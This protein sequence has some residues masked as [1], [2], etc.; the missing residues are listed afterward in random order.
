LGGFFF[1]HY[2]WFMILRGLAGIFIGATY[3]VLVGAVMFLRTRIGLDR[4]H[5]GP[6]IANAIEMAWFVT[7]MAGLITGVCGTLV[8]LAVGLS[9]VDKARAAGIGFSV[10]LLVLAPLS[11]NDWSAWDLLNAS[12]RTRLDLF[13]MLTIRPIGLALMSMF[14]AVVTARLKPYDL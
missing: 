11:I 3:G 12:W 10:G 13:V 1:S 9:G 4:A 6:L 7:V 2:K 14:V 5:P 8:G